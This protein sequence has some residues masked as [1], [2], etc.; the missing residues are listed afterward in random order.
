MKTC[1]SLLISVLLAASAAAQGLGD[2]PAR[3]EETGWLLHGQSVFI[4]QFHPGFTAP[5][6][7]DNSLQSRAM[8][9]NTFSADL[10]LG[11]RLWPGA[12][13]V[14]DAQ[15]TRGFGLSGTTG[16][17]AFPNGE[18]FRI[19]SVDPKLQTP[20]LFLRQSF[21][22]SEARVPTEDMLRFATPLP[23][24]RIT[25]TA[26]KFSVLDIF[27][28][29]AYAHDA[30]TQFLNWSLIAG[31][32]VDWANDAKGY[33]NGLALEWDSPAW[34]V[35]LGAFQV[36]KRLNTLSLDPQP[37][38]GFQLLVELD[39]F[40]EFG[41]RPGAARVIAGV[42][43]TRSR[44][45][46]ALLGG[47]LTAT[48]TN[49][50]GGTV[51]KRMLALNLEQEI[52]DDLGAFA[53]LSWNDGRSQQWMYTDLDWAVAAGLSFGGARWGRPG[54]RLG[55]AAH[56]GGLSAPHRRFLAAGGVSFILGDGRLRYRPEAGGEVFYELP[57]ADGVWLAANAQLIGNPGHNA[58]RGPVPVLALRLRAGF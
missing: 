24:E 55:V 9:R 23:A 28:R 42:S 49:A 15:V 46:A 57:L 1:S 51:A 6:R 39:R 17:A 3:L 30:R 12:E 19:G 29:N 47:D 14:V 25:L 18:A 26:G 21:A 45:Y 53:R 33:T 22:L 44:T 34:G 48:E 58:D 32:A 56:I 4:E 54:D 8:Q 5:Y 7:G 36:A 16:L 2:R 37:F 41:G 43:Q 11:R 13:L 10:I 38:R 27:D 50:R 52:A 35:R 40:F 20:R 31:G